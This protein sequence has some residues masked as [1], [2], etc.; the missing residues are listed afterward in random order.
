[1]EA[2]FVGAQPAGGW[3]IYLATVFTQ[4]QTRL[5]N[6]LHGGAAHFVRDY[7]AKSYFSIAA[8]HLQFV[9]EKMVE[10]LCKALKLKDD[11]AESEKKLKALRD[12]IV[13]A[14]TPHLWPRTV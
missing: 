4:E 3:P 9:P 2:A 12:S 7:P 11:I 5:T 13:L 10:T 14:L 6:S 1:M 8:K